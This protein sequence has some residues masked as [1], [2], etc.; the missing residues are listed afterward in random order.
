VLREGETY[1]MA[2]LGI[3]VVGNST[4]VRERGRREMSEHYRTLRGLLAAVSEKRNGRLWGWEGDGGIAA[5]TFEEQNQRATLAG[6]DFL[7]ELFLYNLVDCPLQDGLHVRVTVHN[8]PCEYHE[9]GT[10]LKADTIKRLWEIDT[11]HGTS[12]TLIVSDS[13][14]PSLERIVAARLTP[15]A[16]GDHNG[17]YTYAVR[18][19]D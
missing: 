14:Y 17:F 15:L 1:I 13:V 16:I 7:T 9:D 2:F 11:K 6:M 4:L 8:G 10:E 19:A 12:D 3:D 18:F 5:F